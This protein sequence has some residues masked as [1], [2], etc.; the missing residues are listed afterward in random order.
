MARYWLVMPAAGSGVRFGDALP[1]QYARLCGRCVIEW[2]LAPFVADTRCAA[3]V[4]AL[5]PG[6]EHWGPIGAALPAVQT[7]TGGAR[8]SD[9]VR[10]ALRLLS[11][12][13]AH[14]EDWVLVHDAARPC[15]AASDRD[16]LLE[17]LYEHRLGG[18]LAT[19][20]ADTLKR[21]EADQTI[22]TTLDRTR[23]WRALT[24]QMFR[25]GPLCAALDAAQSAHRSPT[26][27]AQAFEWLGEHPVLV[28]GSAANI[29]IT[30]AGDLTLAAAVLAARS[31][32]RMRIGTGFDVHAFGPGDFVMLGGVR[33]AHTQGVMAHSDGDVILHALCDALLG[34]AGLG[35]IGEHFVSGDPRW[36]GADSTRFVRLV[37]RMLEE[38]Q[39]RVGNVD[40][41]RA[42]RA[43][44]ARRAPRDDT[45]APR[46]AVCPSP[47]SR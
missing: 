34:A 25:Y 31:S 22:A 40:I 37:M 46:R 3:A 36:K 12:R 33:I 43:A 13:G 27:E 26:D 4:V 19:P 20:Q 10:N 42:R 45:A 38:R 8:R 23:L 35:D 1:K 18:V 16:R 29:K 24:P 7:T 41:T 2:A 14:A 9:S 47:R 17:V 39:L 21:A 15:L 30:N 32:A 6:D 44:A 28:E 11:T 5:A